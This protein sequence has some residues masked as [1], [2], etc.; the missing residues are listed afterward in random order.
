MGIKIKGINKVEIFLHKTF[1]IE[2]HNLL[3]YVSFFGFTASFR[4]VE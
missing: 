3:I 4:G 1:I 2:L